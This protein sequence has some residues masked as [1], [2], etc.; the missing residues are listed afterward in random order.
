MI[1]PEI[2]MREVSNRAFRTIVEGL[3]DLGLL[4]G[5]VDELLKNDAGFTFMPH[6]LGHYI[7]FKTH[8]VGLQV[9]PDKTKD[10]TPEE[11][12][13]ARKKYEPVNS[14]VLEAGMVTTDEP[15]I[16]FIPYLIEKA[17]NNEKTR[18]LYNFDRIEE[19]MCVGGIRIEDCIL[20]TEDGHEYLT[21]VNSLVPA[22]D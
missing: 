10:K 11:A 1:R 12:R 19:Y 2:T 5:E 15:G 3:R 18:H 4:V 20:V 14:A 8:D 7:G 9:H 22:D 6:S 17:R 13:E 16:Y 21:R